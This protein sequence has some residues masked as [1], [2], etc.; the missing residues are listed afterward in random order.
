MELLLAGADSL[1]DS[2]RGRERQRP[3]VHGYAVLRADQ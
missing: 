3:S 2:D 1:H